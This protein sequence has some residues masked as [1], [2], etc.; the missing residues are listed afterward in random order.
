MSSIHTSRH[1]TGKAMLCYAYEYRHEF[2]EGYAIGYLAVFIFQ[3]LKMDILNTC[4][5]P[6]ANGV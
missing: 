1:N 4:I 6:N 5:M 3:V 2:R